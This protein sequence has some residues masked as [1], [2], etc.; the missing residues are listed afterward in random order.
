MKQI[1]VALCLVWAA[2][3]VA[4]QPIYRCGPNGTEYSQTPCPGGKL[5]ES[6]DPRSAAQREEAVR[7]AAQERKRAAEQERERRAQ[8]A[9]TPPARA[10]GFNGRPP[11]PE[12]AAS[13]T[14]RDRYRKRDSKVKTGKGADFV[15]VE[16]GGAKKKHVRR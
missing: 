8:Q 4:A 13:A 9:A 1:V 7:V 14:E 12:A 6:S 10:A 15:A 11:P 2:S 16:P 5:V 3:G